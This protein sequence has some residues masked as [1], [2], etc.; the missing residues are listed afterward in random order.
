MSAHLLF[1]FL[2]FPRIQEKYFL[3]FFVFEKKIINI[4]FPSIFVSV[5]ILYFNLRYRDT[6][7]MP[8][9]LKLYLFPFATNKTELRKKTVAFDNTTN[10]P[11]HNKQPLIF[12]FLLSH[13]TSPTIHPRPTALIQRSLSFRSLPITV[14]SFLN[15]SFLSTLDLLRQFLGISRS[16]SHLEAAKPRRGDRSTEISGD[17]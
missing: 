2:F 3:N 13:Q 16:N 14:R 4:Y 15:L 10:K 11:N 9:A 6:L 12:F 8:W 17:C 1:S 7:K 5:K